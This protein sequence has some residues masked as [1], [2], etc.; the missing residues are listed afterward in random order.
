MYT[1]PLPR[2]SLNP[3][4]LFSLVD[5]I[6]LQVYV[7]SLFLMA[8]TRVS[9]GSTQR[10]KGN[11]WGPQL[12]STIAENTPVPFP[13]ASA[14][15]NP[16]AVRSVA[17]LPSANSG[18]LPTIA[19]SERL[20]NSRFIR[21]SALSAITISPSLGVPVIVTDVP[22]PTLMRPAFRSAALE[23]P[24]RQSMTGLPLLSWLKRYIAWS[25]IMKAPSSPTAKEFSTSS[26]CSRI[27]CT[28]PE[29]I[30]NVPTT[31]CTLANQ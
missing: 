16:M 12:F 17:L 30:C 4:T 18:M 7:P 25:E 24:V 11:V 6:S 3:P 27:C 2:D 5:H 14:C 29:S 13:L 8:S 20:I 23:Y 10:E 26:P 15:S 1:K 22:E 19:P 9:P 28:A 21:G 31:P